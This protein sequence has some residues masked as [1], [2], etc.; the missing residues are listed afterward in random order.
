MVN[1]VVVYEALMRS[2]TLESDSG[3][4]SSPK[5]G[6]QDSLISLLVHDIFGGEILKTHKNK[7]WHFYNMIDGERVD[8]SKTG[9]PVDKN[10]FED[11]PSNPDDI[12]CDQADYSTFFMRFVRAFEESVGLDKYRTGLTA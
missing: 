7:N 8:F 10:R 1:K 2:E 3:L 9:K 12:F 11:I 5:P 6:G 4:S